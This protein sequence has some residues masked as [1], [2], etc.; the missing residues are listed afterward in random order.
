MDII[1]TLK[2]DASNYT[3]NMAKATQSGVAGMQKV[4]A[5]TAKATA[6]LKTQSG[7]I[8][9]LKGVFAGLVTAAAVK[10]AINLAESFDKTS[11]TI[12]NATSSIQEFNAFQQSTFETAQK[13][14]DSPLG[15]L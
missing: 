1:D 15:T 14:S 13:P 6:A 5:E 4:K 7:V 3:A 11:G 12:R 10:G 2:L 8:G 9:S